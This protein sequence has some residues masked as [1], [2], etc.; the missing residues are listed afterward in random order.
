MIRENK[1]KAKLRCGEIVYGLIS[2]S[3]DPLL[4]EWCGLVGF[5]FY[6][7]DAE[8]GAITI[9]QAE[10]IV[11]AS[12]SV[13]ITPLVRLGQFDPKLIQSYLD[14]GMLGVMQPGLKNADEVR[15]LVN[16]VRY[17]PRGARGLGPARA[18]DFFMGQMSQAE[19]VKFANEQMLVLPQFE[20]PEMFTELNAV[21]NT[22]GVDGI[23]IGPRDLA[24]AMGYPDGADHREVQALIQ[25]AMA[26]ARG[27]GLAVGIPASTGKLAQTQIQRG[28][29]LIFVSTHSLM[30]QGARDFLKP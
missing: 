24:L 7:A 17:P 3:A 15:T 1:T 19:Y 12:E 13:N 20:E 4:A 6:M 8:H 22:E 5:D 25:E 26:L 10:N 14:V 30:Q 23:C 11:R 9:S 29:N 27:A 2:L 21:V 28:A 18:N 16:A